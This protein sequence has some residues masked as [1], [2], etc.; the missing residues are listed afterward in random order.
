MKNCWKR[1][2]PEYEF[3]GVVGGGF[4]HEDIEISR[5]EKIAIVSQCGKYGLVF[6]RERTSEE[7]NKIVTEYYQL[8]ECTYDNID[9]I[10]NNN[11]RYCF[12][13]IENYN[14]GISVVNISEKQGMNEA[15]CHPDLLCRFKVAD[16]NRYCKPYFI[17]T[18]NNGMRYYSY[19]DT[20]ISE[21]YEEITLQKRFL[22]CRNTDQKPI[23]V[24]IWTNKILFCLSGWFCEYMCKYENGVVFKDEDHNTVRLVFVNED[25]NKVYATSDFEEIRAE[26]VYTR[27]DKYLKRLFY[28]EPFEDWKT[29]TSKKEMLSHRD[30]TKIIKTNE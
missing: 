26:V 9:Y 24:D 13:M 21:E 3:D 7:Q 8:C 25:E 2:T 27:N 18:S 1:W 12:K 11:K 30:I 16:D 5:I 28:K 4:I 19:A 20:R 23:V 29:V 15:I 17:L 14:V 10:G 6:L 22:V